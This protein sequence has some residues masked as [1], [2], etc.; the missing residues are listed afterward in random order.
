MTLGPPDWAGSLAWA[1]KKPL[2]PGV[3]AHPGAAPGSWSAAPPRDQSS[4]ALFL[5][6]S[7][8]AQNPGKLATTPTCKTPEYLWHQPSVIASS[9]SALNKPLSSSGTPDP[10]HA[11]SLF[12]SVITLLSLQTTH[13]VSLFTS[14]FLDLGSDKSG[15]EHWSVHLPA[16]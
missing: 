10:L 7:P 13:W 2:G 11:G 14:G 3:Q 9:P 8:A 4:K 16:V 5:P 12:W 15:F 1:G 6:L